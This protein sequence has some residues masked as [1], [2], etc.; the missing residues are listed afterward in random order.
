MIQL[1]IPCIIQIVENEVND[2]QLQQ[3]EQQSDNYDYGI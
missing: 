3:F 1:V 2:Q